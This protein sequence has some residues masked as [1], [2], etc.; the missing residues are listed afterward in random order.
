MEQNQNP[1]AADLT[2][3]LPSPAPAALAD[4]NVKT[5]HLDEPITRAS[6]AIRALNIRKPKAGALRGVT[7]TALV[8]VD[9]GALRVVLPRVCDPILTPA[10]INNLE[11]QDL[12]SVGATLASFFISRAEREAI[13][14]P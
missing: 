14:T 9:V 3:T 11:P 4:E 10:E 7:L 6:G 12:L 5:V 1:Q 2:D 8:S 13:Q